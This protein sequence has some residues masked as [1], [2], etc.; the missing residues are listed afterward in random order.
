MIIDL[1]DLKRNL[2][3][4][5]DADDQLLKDLTDRAVEFVERE[6]GFYFGVPKDHTEYLTGRGTNTLYL[7]DR[8]AV[9]PTQ[10]KERVHVGDANPVTIL[11]AD[12]DGFVIRNDR[13]LVRKSGVWFYGYEY[14]VAYKRGYTAGSAPGWV[15][16]AVI[17]FVRLFYQPEGTA[18]GLKSE[19]VRNYSYTVAD[20]EDT[21]VDEAAL[22]AFV[23]S[24]RRERV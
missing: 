15:E 5:T 12:D 10:V 20:A 17:R 21:Q 19:T 22:L 23:R 7:A 6:T 18:A 9:A 1:A 3:V 2:R 14:E 16:Q 11:P 24:K 13:A 4:T 8:V